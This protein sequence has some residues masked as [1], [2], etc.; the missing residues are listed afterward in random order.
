[1]NATINQL[2][3]EGYCRLAQ[4][5]GNPKAKPNPIPPLVPV[6]KSTWY[7]GIKSGKFPA[8]VYI[9]RSSLW[10]WADIRKL[11]ERIEKGEFAHEQG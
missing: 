3:T 6:S 10:K 5:L 7:D 4:I 8:P 1:M 9:G 11:L 2:P